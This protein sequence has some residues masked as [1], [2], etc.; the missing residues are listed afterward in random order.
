MLLLVAGLV[1]FLGAH[2]ARIVAEPA[3]A[4]FVETRGENAWKGL[5]SLVSIAGLVLI[6]VG[7]RAAPEVVVWVP[8]TWLRHVTLSLVAIAFVL[9]AAAYVPDNRI[10]GAVGHPMVLGVKVWAFA[11]LLVNGTLA[12]IVLFGAF[13][14]W[15]VA[16]FASSRRRDRR[17]G[18]ERRGGGS[19]AATVATLGVGL[20]AWIVFAGWLHR[21]IIGVSPF[22]GA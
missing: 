3:R 11:H 5:Y 21:L 4:R 22:G 7:Y 10:R 9:V 15:A 12:G 16:D 1:L 17:A 14:V 8:P 20:V 2:S 19:A 13:L 18:V 6:V